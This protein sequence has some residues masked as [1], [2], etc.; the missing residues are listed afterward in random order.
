MN[1]QVLVIDDQQDT[2]DLY[3]MALEAKGL[4]CRGETDPRRAIESFRANPTDVVVVDYKFPK[5]K[6]IN[7]VTIISD[8]QAIKPFTRFILISGWFEKELTEEAL[9][10][11]LQNRI[12]VWAY[13]HKPT[14]VHK[15]VT[16]VQEA[17]VTMD[18]L[19]SDWK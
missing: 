4:T 5:F 8:L 2:V 14:D 1:E 15:V 19:T 17:L 9:T 11:Q 10:Q 7:G 3:C 16:T 12:N 6:E 18:A 13:L